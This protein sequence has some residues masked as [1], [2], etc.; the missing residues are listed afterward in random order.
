MYASRVYTRLYA[1][2]LD[3]LGTLLCHSNEGLKMSPG[4]LWRENSCRV[5]ALTE[6]PR[7]GKYDVA[8]VIQP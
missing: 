1:A 7:T 2:S 5:A 8:S 4:L 3:P 6:P